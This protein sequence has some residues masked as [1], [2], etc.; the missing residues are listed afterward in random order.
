MA[1]LALRNATCSVS[2]G[3][4]LSA[5][6][7]TNG[8]QAASLPALCQRVPPMPLAASSPA[9]RPAGRRVLLLAGWALVLAAV[10]HLLIP[11]LGPEAYSWTGAPRRLVEMAR[12]G[13]WRPLLSCLVIASLLYGAALYA[14][15]GAGSIR[16]LPALRGVLA[17]LGLG[18]LLRG[19]GFVLL[20]YGN[21]M[22]LAQVCG[23]CDSANAFVWSTSLLCTLLGVAF[24]WGLVA[25]RATSRQGD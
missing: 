12:A 2:F 4:R 6:A 11:L 18:L 23:R 17:L 15:S 19:V 25:L 9:A 8:L 16:R 3:A 7:G 13:S 5:G 22:Q 24:V 20:A 1:C 14:F 10:L 21:P